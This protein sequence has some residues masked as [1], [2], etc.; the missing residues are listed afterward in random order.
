MRQDYSAYFYPALGGSSSSNTTT[1]NNSNTNI[2]LNSGAG[3]SGSSL[4]NRPRQQGRLKLCSRGLL[5]EPADRLLPLVKYPFRHMETQMEP[6]GAG[7]AGEAKMWRGA[8]GGG[9]GGRGGGGGGGEGFRFRCTVVVE[10][11]RNDEVGPYVTKRARDSGTKVEWSDWTFSFSLLH[12]PLE[13]FLGAA[14]RLREVA[15]RVKER[16]HGY[17]GPLLRPLLEERLRDSTQKFD[18]M[19]L[20]DFRETLLLPCPVRVD[21]ITPLL[22]NP[23]CIMVTDARV[24]F[25]PADLN[26]VGEPVASFPN[27]GVLRAFKRR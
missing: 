20:V 23:G 3:G 10:S 24:Y 9:G 22:R 21:R 18:T 2:Y 8:V 27:A 7:A 13:E 19:H 17:E 12:T 26:N 4:K 11:R 15:L 14:R 6:V 5:F 1:N 16:G 25:Q